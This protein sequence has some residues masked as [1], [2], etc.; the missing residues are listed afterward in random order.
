[1]F[2]TYE[3][4][5]MAML[6]SFIALIFTGFPVAWILAGLAV[7]FSCVGIIGYEYLDW[8][9]YYMT[10]WRIYGTFVQRIYAQMSNWVLVAL[11]MFIFMGLMLERS[12][13][14][15]KLMVNFVRLFGRFRG[16]LGVSVILIGILFAAS[17]GIV[18]ASVVLL[19]M[20]SMPV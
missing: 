3:I 4:L 12:G 15:E 7:V 5:V 13:V 19:A 10:N 1:M 16:G 6:G 9:T 17:T 14:A 11:P 20:L 2:E 18:G 8:D